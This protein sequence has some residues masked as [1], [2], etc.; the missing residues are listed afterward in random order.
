[1]NNKKIKI[2]SIIMLLTTLAFSIIFFYFSNF[3]HNNSNNSIDKVI[4]QPIFNFEENTKEI[5]WPQIDVEKL[6]KSFIDYSGN[7]DEE[8][9]REI[10]EDEFFSKFN[11]DSDWI[12][13]NYKFDEKNIF[14]MA[15]Y[16]LRIEDGYLIENNEH[17]YKY[18]IIRNT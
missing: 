2:I 5:E 10:F 13:L 18:S 12:T 14:V 11:Y 7:I 9:F 4:E 17:I 3:Y 1:M 6:N 15:K 8:K 16:N